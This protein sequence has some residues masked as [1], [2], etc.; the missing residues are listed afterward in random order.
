MLPSF[1]RLII[2]YRNVLVAITN[3]GVTW[4]VLIIA[5]LGLFAVISCTGLVFLSSLLVGFVGD[6]ALLALLKA[7]DPQ[8]VKAMRDR[9]GRYPTVQ[10]SNRQLEHPDQWHL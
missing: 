9:T 8:S 2:R 6:Q 4:I 1:T 3:A 5:P 10:E 7:A